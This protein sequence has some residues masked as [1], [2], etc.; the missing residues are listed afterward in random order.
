MLK[1]MTVLVNFRMSEHLK[2]G[3]DFIA[4][5]K[6]TTKTYII[7]T[8]LENY[9]RDEYQQLTADKEM[10]YKLITANE[11]LKEKYTEAN[12]LEMPPVFISTDIG[13]W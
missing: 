6:Q 3:L 9:I 7:N 2:T 8:L 4:R 13:E 12:D 5:S 11:R 10:T 1:I